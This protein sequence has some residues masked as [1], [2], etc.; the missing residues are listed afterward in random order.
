MV[1]AGSWDVAIDSEA[2][3]QIFQQIGQV[4]VHF[5]ALGTTRKDAGSAAKFREIDFGYVAKMGQ[6]FFPFL[7]RHFHGESPLTS[8]LRSLLDSGIQQG[9]QQPEELQPRLLSRG[10]PEL[11]VPLSSGEG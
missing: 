10:E 1:R 4:P 9:V 3:A 8:F 7:P 5:S 2:S 11:L 6:C